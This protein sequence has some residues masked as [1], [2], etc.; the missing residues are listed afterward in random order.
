MLSRTP[1]GGAHVFAM[2]RVVAILTATGVASATALYAFDLPTEAARASAVV[3][4]TPVRVETYPQDTA[5]GRD[6]FTFTTL[7]VERV[8]KG[9]AVAG[10]LLVITARGGSYSPET[11]VTVADELPVPEVGAR[12]V[13][14]LGAD[15]NQPWNCYVLQS[16]SLAAYLLDDE[17]GTTRA[18]RLSPSAADVTAGGL[19]RSRE[20]TPAP[21]ATRYTDQVLQASTR[22]TSRV[23]VLNATDS[24][25]SNRAPATTLAR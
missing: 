16:R 3:V 11:L 20:T 4:S 6:V 19:A 15:R 24:A 9:D 21:G 12:Y 17:D 1:R 13:L 23:R 2:A 14:Y 25:E 5:S 8:P 22:Y 18:T 10:E 7:S